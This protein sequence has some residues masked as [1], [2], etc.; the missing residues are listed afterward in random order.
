MD[1][2]L[3]LERDPLPEEFAS[4]TEAGTFWDTHSTAAYEDFT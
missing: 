4:L 3:P 2:H 1:K